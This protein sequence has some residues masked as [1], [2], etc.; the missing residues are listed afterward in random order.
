MFIEINGRSS[1]SE[2]R[3]RRLSNTRPSSVHERASPVTVHYVRNMP[4]FPA[5]DRLCCCSSC[6]RLEIGYLLLHCIQNTQNI[7]LSVNCCWR[8]GRTQTSHNEWTTSTLG[9]SSVQSSDTYVER[10]KQEGRRSTLYIYTMEM[11]ILVTNNSGCCPNQWVFTGKGR[12]QK[13]IAGEG[14]VSQ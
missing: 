3:I 9:A 1:C 14:G 10:S 6:P 11:D 7:H 8:K 5:A 2:G 13:S 12:E 4:T